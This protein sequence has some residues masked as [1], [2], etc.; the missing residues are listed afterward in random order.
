MVR[1]Y[2]EFLTFKIFSKMGYSSNYSFSI[3]LNCLSLSDSFLLIYI[4]GS[5]LPSDSWSNTAPMPIS[6]LSVWTIKVFSSN[7]QKTAGALWS[8]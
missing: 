3:V 8:N 7:F 6:L 5:F 4:I 1:F 2:Q